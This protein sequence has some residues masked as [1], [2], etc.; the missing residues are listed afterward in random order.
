MAKRKYLPKSKK[1]QPVPLKLNYT[2]ESGTNTSYIDLAKDVSVLA[3]KF[4]RQ[5]KLFAVANVRVTMPAAS[6]TVGNSVYLSGMQNTWTVSN[7]WH[8]AFAMWRRQQDEAVEASGSESAVARYR[9][10]KIFL[11]AQHRTS[12]NLRPVNLGPGAQQG[13]FQGPI[14]TSARPLEGE[15]EYSQIVIP[16]DGS[17]GVTNEY[18]LFMHGFEGSGTDKSIIHGYAQ[19]RSL[20]QRVAP[21]TPIGAVET[22]WMNNMFDVGDDNDEVVQNALYHNDAL[23]YDQDEY[24]GGMTNYVDPEN[25]AWCLNKSTVG[26]NTFNLGAMV[27]PCGLLRIDQLYSATGGDLVIEIELLPGH[28]RGYALADMQDM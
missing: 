6:S 24:P 25:K 7:A 23:P 26:V 18:Y 1:V 22:S 9:D 11:D 8:K 20:P 12:G 15:W 27:L 19:S 14:V 28:D 2:I 10:F 3:R 17:P 5:G 13:P 4:I 16:N 21:A